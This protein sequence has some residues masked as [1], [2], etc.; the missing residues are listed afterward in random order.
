MKE[1]EE[2]EIIMRQANRLLPLCEK[3]KITPNSIITSVIGDVHS[4]TLLEKFNLELLDEFLKKDQVNLSNAISR[5]L[6]PRE[7]NTLIQEY[8]RKRVNEAL[9]AERKEVF[10]GLIKSLISAVIHRNR[11][12]ELDALQDS[13]SA[14]DVQ[15]IFAMILYKI[16]FSLT[17]RSHL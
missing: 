11:D 1:E 13:H 15:Y 8:F 16:L 12:A 5:G 9:C 6:S 4:A 7:Y 14:E 10:E 3:Q 17:G 2:E